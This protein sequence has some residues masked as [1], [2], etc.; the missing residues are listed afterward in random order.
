MKENIYSVPNFYVQSDDND[1]EVVDDFGLNEKQ[2]ADLVKRAKKA[3]SE[4]HGY[5]DT[6][7]D[8]M[9]NDWKMYAADQWSEEAKLARR[10]RPRLTLNQLPKFVK[11][12]IAQT[13][14]EPPAIKLS[15]RESSDRLKADIATGLVRYIEDASGAKYVY[16]HALEC[17]VIGG[18]GWIK[19]SFDPV[20]RKILIK[21]VKDPFYYMADPDSEEIDGSDAKYFIA[22]IKKKEGKKS[23]D[24]YEYW[25][26][27]EGKVFWAII[28]E[29]KIED[30]GEFPG[31][32][33]PIFPVFGEE[34]TYRDERILKGIIRDL[35]DAQRTYNYVKS[36]EVEIV[37]LTP[38]APVIAEE[39]TLEGYEGDWKRASKTP[40]DILY[41]K[42]TNLASEPAQPPTFASTQPNITWSPQITQ[43]AMSDLREISGIY[44]TNLGADA[45]GQMSGKAIIAKQEAGDSGQLTYTEHLQATIQQVG[46]WVLGMIAPVLGEETSIRILGEDGKQSIVDT[47][48][49]QIDPVTG[50]PVMLDLNFAEMDISVSSGPA[51]STRREASSR[52]I[53]EIMTALPNSAQ[54]IADIAVRNLDL[55]GADEAANRLYKMLPPQL[56]ESQD[57][58]LIPRETADQI[59]NQSEATIQQQQQLIQR[60]QTEIQSLHI[61]LQNQTQAKLA[62]E[63]MKSQTSIAVA[64]IKEAGANERKMADVAARTASDNKKIAMSVLEAQHTPP[65]VPDAPEQVTLNNTTVHPIQAP[66]QAPIQPIMYRQGD[67]F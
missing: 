59:M 62:G 57:N 8:E 21:K 42:K 14:K 60:M 36:Q 29:G 5:W 16:S 39:G 28:N 7:Y 25:Y 53:Q 18:L 32:I 27:D 45:G 10:G 11:R 37:A 3:A 54:F 6:K 46:R 19:G 4:A 48:T 41:Y 17:A 23:L 22:H 30:Y 66:I 9:E 67:G 55:P 63:Q 56:I 15:P 61:E 20:Q 35:T 65:P 40:V 24:C 26:K 50:Q 38:K 51:Y 43:G 13:R 1:A 12:I 44:D 34:I 52:A 2:R 33:I 58:G 64:Q 47:S 31:A 49:A